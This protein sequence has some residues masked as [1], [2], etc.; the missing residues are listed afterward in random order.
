MKLYTKTGDKGATGMIGG[1]RVPKHSL[2]IIVVGNLD[3]LNC[4]LGL[5]ACLD[6]AES[7]RTL[8]IQVQSS[9][10]DAGA[11]ASAQGSMPGSYSA[12]IAG[13][14]EDIDRLSSDLPEM[15]NFIL[16][17]GCQESACLH[18]ARAV[19]RR[20]ERSLAEMHEGSPFQSEILPFVNRLSDWLFVAA[21]WENHRRGLADV[22]WI[23]VKEPH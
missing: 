19:C 9:V 3:E 4:Q 8:L 23:K 5:C 11:E 12:L 6:L 17:G 21:R 2:P 16:P 1:S 7:T 20:A 15:R 22:P 13:L 18:I 14:E 10:F